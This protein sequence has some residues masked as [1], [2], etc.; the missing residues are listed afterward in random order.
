MTGREEWKQA[1]DDELILSHLGTAD[2]YNSAKEALHDLCKWHE[3]VGA[4]FARESSNR[5]T[6]CSDRMP[7]E[8]DA[9]LRGMVFVYY[10]WNGQIILDMPFWIKDFSEWFVDRMWWMPTGLVMPDPPEI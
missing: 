4:Y 9:D 1:I 10:E 6:R 5:W 8:A 3:E 7:T 2:S